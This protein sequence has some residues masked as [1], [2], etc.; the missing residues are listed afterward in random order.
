[1]TEYDPASGVALFSLHSSQ[2]SVASISSCAWKS[3]SSTW[4][5]GRGL[6]C[7]SNIVATPPLS[8]S[9]SS[10]IMCIRPEGGAVGAVAILGE[11]EWN[12]CQNSHNPFDLSI[13]SW[14]S[15]AKSLH[16]VQQSEL[17]PSWGS[18][19]N[20]LEIQVPWTVSSL[21]SKASC[22]LRLGSEASQSCSPGQLSGLKYAFISTEGFM[23]PIRSSIRSGWM[24]EWYL[25][26]GVMVETAHAIRCA[27][28]T[29]LPSMSC[30][31]SRV[32]AT[33]F[34]T[35]P[36]VVSQSL[37]LFLARS[38][39]TGNDFAIRLVPDSP[40]L[41]SATPTQISLQQR[42]PLVSAI[43]VYAIVEPPVHAS[44]IRLSGLALDV[45]CHFGSQVAVNANLITPALVHCPLQDMAQ[46][47]SIGMMQMSI[48]IGGVSI[49]GRVSIEVQETAISGMSVQPTAFAGQWNERI[50]IQYSRENFHASNCQFYVGL[51]LDPDR[52]IVVPFHSA[53]ANDLACNSGWCM[54]PNRE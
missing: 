30:N 21:P 10:N 8:I 48:D 50:N 19:G 2:M 24:E 44:M 3:E 43:P 42:D 15:L 22:L 1:M 18:I 23:T 37:D 4:T 53:C 36:A 45:R 38:Q 13:S 28:V 34:G 40:Q 49:P 6:Q 14:T 26:D 16:Q 17:S 29:V 31:A 5:M 20:A 7:G 46:N 39:D 9:N 35:S 54:L 25:V 32:I 51:Q 27:A 12:L 41:L 33:T 47:G 52:R 11:A